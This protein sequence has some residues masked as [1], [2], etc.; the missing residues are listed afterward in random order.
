MNDI[1]YVYLVG[2]TEVGK[3][4]YLILGIALPLLLEKGIRSVK[5]KLHFK[6]NKLRL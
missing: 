6:N 2:G 5:E 3:W 4:I 1:N